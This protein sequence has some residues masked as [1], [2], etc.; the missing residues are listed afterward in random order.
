MTFERQ[1]CRN[2]QRVC[3]CVDLRSLDIRKWHFKHPYWICEY[4]LP[5]VLDPIATEKQIKTIMVNCG[6]EDIEKC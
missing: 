3:F 5:K 2:C 1:K 6:I 4:D